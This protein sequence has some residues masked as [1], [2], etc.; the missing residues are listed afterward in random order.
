MA[1]AQQP[2]FTPPSIHRLELRDS[3]KSGPMYR[4]M[5]TLYQTWADLIKFSDSKQRIMD[6]TLLLPSGSSQKPVKPVLNPK[7][8]WGP[9]YNSR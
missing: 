5:E 9:G 2:R 8:R 4:P 6:E 3:E 7:P 1:Q